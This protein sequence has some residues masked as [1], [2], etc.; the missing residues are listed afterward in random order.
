M[1]TPVQTP[2]PVPGVPFAALAG[3]LALARWDWLELLKDEAAAARPLENPLFEI[4]N[5]IWFLQVRLQ[6]VMGPAGTGLEA[7][8]E[9]IARGY[10]SNPAGNALVKTLAEAVENARALVPAA[11]ERFTAPEF[12]PL[13]GGDETHG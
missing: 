2:A 11:V 8:I 10:T 4:E 5:F 3:A 1:V 13:Y 6:Q 9:S 12:S 7:H